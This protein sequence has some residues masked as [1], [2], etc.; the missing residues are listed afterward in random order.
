MIIPKENHSIMNIK[1][2]YK[3]IKLKDFLMTELGLSSRLFK[4]LIKEKNIFVNNKPLNDIY[5][6]VKDDMITIK[7]EDEKPV[8][9]AQKMD[10]D[11]IYEDLDLIAINKNPYILVHPTKTHIENTLTNAIAYYFKSNNI[12]KKVRLVNRLDMDTSGILIVAKNPYGQAQMAKQFKNNIEKKY[13]AIV[14]GIIKEDKGRIDLPIMKEEGG[15]KQIVDERGKRAITEFKVIKRL[16]N[17]TIVELK[18]ITGKT[19]QIRV[20][21]T[22]LGHPI[23]GDSLYGR[24]SFLIKRQALHSYYLKFKSIRDQ[25]EIELQSDLPYDM[26]DLI[27]KLNN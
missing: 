17:S 2:N 11:I 16:K 19:H 26:K 7:F 5:N 18:I 23:I 8:Y 10:L 1:V 27:K 6:L 22:H 24:E 25:K 14:D 9:K 3:K 21:L 4:K 13:I 12:N 15:I 20:H